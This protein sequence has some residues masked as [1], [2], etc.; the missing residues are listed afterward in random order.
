MKYHIPTNEQIRNALEGVFKRANTVY[1][2][3]KLKELVLKELNTKKGKYGVTGSRLRKIAIESSFVKIEI[4]SREG[5]PKKLMT[6]C[7]VCGH[8]LKR[9][10][11]KT[12]WGGEVTIEFS[13]SNC[14]YWTGKKKRIPTKYVFYNKRR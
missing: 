3:E 10:K 5:N 2:Q 9:V 6:K 11:N 8:D 14:G 13:C 4:H 1:S 7:P 12:I